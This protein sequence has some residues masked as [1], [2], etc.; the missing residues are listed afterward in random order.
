VNERVMKKKGTTICNRE[1][2][3]HKA[4]LKPCRQKK[5]GGEILADTQQKA[6]PQFYQQPERV[7]KIVTV[8]DDFIKT[9]R[10]RDHRT[11][12]MRRGGTSQEDPVAAQQ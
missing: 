5:W 6:L 3:T 4:V 11:A 7:R 8:K 10:E 2:L 12:P 1:G 9:R